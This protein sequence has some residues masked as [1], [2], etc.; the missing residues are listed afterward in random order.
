MERGKILRT[1][2]LHEEE[3]VCILTCEIFILSYLLFTLPFYLPN[4]I[5]PHPHLISPLQNF[6][7]HPLFLSGTFFTWLLFY[8]FFFFI[9]LLFYQSSFFTQPFIVHY[10]RFA[11]WFFILSCFAGRGY[12]LY[13]R[14][15]TFLFQCFHTYRTLVS[16]TLLLWLWVKFSLAHSFFPNFFCF[17]VTDWHIDWLTF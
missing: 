7:T 16:L 15:V 4:P 1:C 17:P 13:P 3:F 11:S 8:Q 2:W 5:L 10:M 6:Y 12:F 9:W 14:F